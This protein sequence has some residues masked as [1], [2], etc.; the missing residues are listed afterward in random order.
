MIGRKETNN[1]DNKDRGTTDGN[2]EYRRVLLLFLLLLLLHLFFCFAGRACVWQAD[3]KA[4]FAGAADPMPL[5][6]VFLGTA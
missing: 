5:G 4:V 1:T 6:P 3:S 2:V